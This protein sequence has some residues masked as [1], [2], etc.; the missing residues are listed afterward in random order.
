MLRF[1]ALFIGIQLSLFLVNMLNWVQQHA[2][3]PWTALLA[4]ISAGLVTWFD[5]S[6]AAQGTP[7]QEL[8]KALFSYALEVA[9]GRETLSEQNGYHDI[10]IF[11]TGVT[12]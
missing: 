4:R 12:L 11:K 9:G 5:A 7:I 10:A 3:L 1:F 6:A 2:V 8:G